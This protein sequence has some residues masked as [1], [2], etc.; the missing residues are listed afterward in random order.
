MCSLELFDLLVQFVGD[1]GTITL[2]LLKR[3]D[4]LLQAIN[5]LK[6]AGGFGL[7]CLQFLIL[8][9]L[10]LIDL[11]SQGFRMRI[12]L[13]FE[14]GG[15]L[16]GRKRSRSTARSRVVISSGAR[17]SGLRLSLSERDGRRLGFP[18]PLRRV[19]S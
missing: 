16:I 8:A 11:G 19:A 4:L 14:F 15:G 6:M 18:R 5:G 17:N 1:L 13:G 12:A 3:F 7:F 10:Q 9:R 2:A